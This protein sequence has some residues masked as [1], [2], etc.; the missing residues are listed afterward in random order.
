MT[1]DDGR[2]LISN[3]I[4][5][6]LTYRTCMSAVDL[7]MW[8]ARLCTRVHTRTFVHRTTLYTTI[9]IVKLPNMAAFYKTLVDGHRGRVGKNQQ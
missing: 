9:E 8:H 3:L 5:A 4:A 6:A 2:P 7:R 1:L